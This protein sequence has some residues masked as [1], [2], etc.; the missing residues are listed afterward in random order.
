MIPAAFGYVRP[1]SLSEALAQLVESGE[2]A[3]L[4]SGGHSLL[5]MMKLRLAAPATLIDIAGLAELQGVTVGENEVVIGA[6]TTHAQ[7]EH[8]A[9]VAKALPLIPAVA[10]LIADPIVRNRGT[11]GGSL[12]HADP[13]ADWPAAMLALDAKIDVIGAKGARSI[14][15]DAFFKG[16][17]ETD[18]ALDEILVRVR[19][20][21][22]P[23]RRVAYRKFRHPAS[24]YA[25]VGV[26]VVVDFQ[27]ERCAGGRIAVTGFADHA[28]R[29]SSAEAA[30]AGYAG[31]PD[32][33]ERLLDLAFTG[34][35]PLEDRFADADYRTQLGRTMLRR[36]LADVMASD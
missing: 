36:A 32:Q 24:G 4:I 28:F 29:A 33:A 20:P 6:A 7:L 25:V 35:I 13:S 16:L 31:Q 11:L 14:P 8:H 3:K 5:P 30:L 34:T 19:I 26:A 22:I 1:C 10:H 17:F 12:A 15:A 2:G 27:A 23:G 18:L 9:E 21:V